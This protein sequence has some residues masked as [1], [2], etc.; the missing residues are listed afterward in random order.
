MIANVFRRVIS[1]WRRGS[2]TAA[3]PYSTRRG[4]RVSAGST[5]RDGEEDD[6]FAADLDFVADGLVVLLPELLLARGDAIDEGREGDVIDGI[7]EG[8]LAGDVLLED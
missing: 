1:R 7:A 5:E 3:A 6:L 4:M 8:L 2:D